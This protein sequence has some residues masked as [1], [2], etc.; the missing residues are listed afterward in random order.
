MSYKINL[1]KVM[2]NKPPWFKNEIFNSPTKLGRVV[3]LW[4]YHI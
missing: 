4:A 1:S 2:T 3:L